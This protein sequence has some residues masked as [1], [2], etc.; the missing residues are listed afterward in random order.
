MEAEEEQIGRADGMVSCDMFPSPFPFTKMYKWGIIR[1]II[2][3]YIRVYCSK[4]NYRPWEEYTYRFGERT[5]MDEEENYHFDNV[6][7]GPRVVS[8]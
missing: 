5:K 7:G 8:V 4:Y 2:S 3:P 6:V 1:F